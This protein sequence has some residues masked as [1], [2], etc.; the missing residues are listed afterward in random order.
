MF[1]DDTNLFLTNNNIKNLYSDMNMELNKV[2]IWFR[3]NKLSLNVEKTNYTLF[4]KIKKQELNIPLMLP[5]LYLNDKLIKKQTSIKFLGILVD[6]SLSW[7]PQINYIQSKITRTIGVMYRFRPYVNISSLKLIYFGLIH[8]FINYANISWASIHK[9]KLEKIYKLQK[10]A[11]RIIYSKH[12]REHAKPLMNDMK[13][14]DIFEINIYQH[15]IFMYRYYNNL[16]PVNFNDKFELK[17]N[18]KYNLRSNRNINYKL[19]R[20]CNKLSEYCIS[21]QEPKLWNECQ[22]DFKFTVKSL[23]SF[24]FQAKKEIFKM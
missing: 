8:C 5:E 12:K 24:K 18:D 22:K 2:N 3:A 4:H 14:M 17:I 15:L 7:L 9:T 16:L 6:E 13:M 21:Y 20:K 19:P 10:H 1:A 11:C 23:S